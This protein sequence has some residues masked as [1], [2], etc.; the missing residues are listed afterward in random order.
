MISK[1]LIWFKRDLRMQDHA[2]LV[3]AQAHD[4]ALGLYIIEPAWLQSS[5]CDPQHV[6]FTLACLGELRTALAA[7]GLPLQVEVGEANACDSALLAPTCSA[8]K[9]P[10]RVGVMHAISRS[11]PGAAST[12]WHG[13]NGRR[14]GWCVACRPGWAG[15]GA[16]PHAWTRR[17]P[18]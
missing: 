7:R 17:K 2:P 18:R 14:T 4:Q 1:A 8:T 10:V 5:E 6:D 3:A 13:G 15:P 11:L 9:K 12:A 16:G